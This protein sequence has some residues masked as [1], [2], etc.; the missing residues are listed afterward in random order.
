MVRAQFTNFGTFVNILLFLGSALKKLF[1]FSY[2][3]VNSSERQIEHKEKM[4]NM[5]KV[6]QYNS[7]I[8]E[9]PYEPDSGSASG[10]GSGSSVTFET[11]HM[12]FGSTAISGIHTYYICLVSHAKQYHTIIV[13]DRVGQTGCVCS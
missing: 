10:S 7:Y 11:Q 6:S 3:S 13:V 1:P 2:F 12:C 8:I 4:N 9:M 5:S